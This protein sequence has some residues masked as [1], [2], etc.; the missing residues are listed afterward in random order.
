[1]SIP[2]DDRVQVRF[3]GVGGQGI[4]LMGRLLGKAAA[5]YDNKEAVATQSYGPE[6]RG[7]AS[8]SDVVISSQ[9]IDFPFVT[10]VDVLVA[11]FQE[12]YQRHRGRLAR[13]GLMIVES[14]LVKPEHDGTEI[15]PVPATRMAEDLGRKV[16]ANVV[17]LGYLVGRTGVVSRE[18]LEEAIRTTVKAKVVP[19]D[20]EA[21][22]AGIQLARTHQQQ[23]ADEAAAP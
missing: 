9:P 17:M 19:L 2:A 14:D 22:E 12:A 20:L 16:V 3:S 5:L 6:A 18:S 8:R 13:G 15:C 1:M 21:V 7:G 23:K 4:V 11:F 10:E